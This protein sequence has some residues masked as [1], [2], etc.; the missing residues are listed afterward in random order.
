MI[1]KII[2]CYLIVLCTVFEIGCSKKSVQYNDFTAKTLTPTLVPTVVITENNV[3]V[4]PGTS[5]NTA[6]E[7]VAINDKDNIYS[8][9][10]TQF[11]VERLNYNKVKIQYSYDN[12]NTWASCSIID[13]PSIIDCFMG[14]SS[15]QFGWLIINGDVGAGSQ[16]HYIY[17][18]EDGGST[19]SE[20]GNTNELG[21]HML[22]GAGFSEKK[23]G[24][25][26]YIYQDGP[27][28]IA[29]LHQTLDGGIT[30]EMLRLELPE[31][32]ADC[33]AQA[34][35]PTFDGNKGVMPIEVVNEKIRETINCYSN[36]YGKT[37]NFSKPDNDTEP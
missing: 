14:F 31:K 10:D 27:T 28:G 12:G 20:I 29:K 35:A 22:S 9:N 19:W 24:L 25:L 5:K 21:S 7:T 32:Y 17:L 15:N 36:D 30:W 16:F 8:Y 13:C 3:L 11:I 33:T 26:N 34:L 23:V 6:W 2:L 4:T 1:K 37:W 18:T